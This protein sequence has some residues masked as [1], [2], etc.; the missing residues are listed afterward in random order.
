MIGNQEA[1][2]EIIDM[3]VGNRTESNHMPLEIEIGDGGAELQKTEEKKEEEKEER[4]WI[5]ESMEKYL[6]E[7]KNWTCKG[8][9]IEEM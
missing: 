1:T 6:E 8:R 5:N 3:K 2:E 4:E 7:C 9:R